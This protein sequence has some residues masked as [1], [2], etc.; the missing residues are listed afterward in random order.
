MSPTSIADNRRISG[1]VEQS[2]RPIKRDEGDL[3]VPWHGI[4]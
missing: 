1:E 2:K 3:D 4:T